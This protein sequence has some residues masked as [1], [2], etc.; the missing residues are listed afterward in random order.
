MENGYLAS[1]KWAKGQSS[2]PAFHRATFQLGQTGDTFLDMS[3]WGKGAV[4]V[5][6]HNL[7]RY[8]SVGPQKTLYCPGPWLKQGANE[9]IVLDIEPGGV[10]RLQGLTSPVWVQ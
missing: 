1:L 7:G 2:E 6:G 3:G 8:W 5:N 9:V 4:W 10:R